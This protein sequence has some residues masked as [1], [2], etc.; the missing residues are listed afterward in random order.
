M[1][2]DDYEIGG[3]LNPRSTNKIPPQFLGGGRQSD[4]GGALNVAMQ[5]PAPAP[6]PALVPVPSPALAPQRASAPRPAQALAHFLQSMMQQEQ[7][8]Q[9]NG[10]N[11][12][13]NTNGI[14][15]GKHPLNPAFQVNVQPQQPVLPAAS[16]V[17]NNIMFQPLG[18]VPQGPTNSSNQ[19]SSF[20]P[21]RFLAP[22]IENWIIKGKVIKKNEPRD[23]KNR[24]GRLFNIKLIDQDGTEIQATFF[25]DAVDRWYDF[26][27]EN[28]VYNI[29]KGHVKLNQFQIGVEHKFCLIL[30]A[31][32]I[33]EPVKD[34]STISEKYNFTTIE[35]VREMNV[36]ETTDVIGIIK[37]A[38]PVM[39]QSLG[40]ETKWMK[41]TI[42]IFDW[43]KAS[44][45]VTLWGDFARQTNFDKGDII[46]LKEVLVTIF[47]NQKI[48]CTFFNTRIFTRDTIPDK[49][50]PELKIIEL[51]KNLGTKEICPSFEQGAR[52]P[53]GNRELKSIAE[54]TAE[55]KSLIGD[56]TKWFDVKAHA[57]AVLER[58]DKPVY[59]MACPDCKR[60]IEE[61]QTRYV[62][63]TCKSYQEP[64]PM[65]QC[66]VLFEDQ[67]G[68]LCAV[69]FNEAA[70]PLFG[71]SATEMF[72]KYR[73]DQAE[74]KMLVKESTRNR[75]VKLRILGKLDSYRDVRKVRF[76]VH[77]LEP[78]NDNVASQPLPNEPENLEANIFASYSQ[79]NEARRHY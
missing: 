28:G 6:A 50:L 68:Q 43:S 35:K 79:P 7:Q 33:I 21:I 52:D 25:N 48:L 61:D 71:R 24:K 56:K 19:N 55:A 66:Q 53:G 49:C 36:K 26:I 64:V 1:E 63:H 20:T 65:Y 73:E 69:L 22:F 14:N 11:G 77:R 58:D 78:I 57:I 51:L 9:L 72:L 8:Q 76:K 60:K 23:F 47:N 2:Y 13:S 16:G 29:S 54:V 41:R 62:C 10:N 32:S 18:S 31:D 12:N 37:S 27:Q 59:Y 39:E 4:M 34:D 3:F 46:I 40:D 30:E 75:E 15:F 44:I 38:G 70:I 42:A 5:P 67:T 45:D 17:G 74:Y